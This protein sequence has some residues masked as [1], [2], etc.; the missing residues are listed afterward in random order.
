MPRLWISDPMLHLQDEIVPLHLPLLQ[1]RDARPQHLPLLLKICIPLLQ[2][3]NCDQARL[4]A[5]LQLLHLL[6]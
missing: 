3:L 2:I 6:A 4:L 5:A 1:L